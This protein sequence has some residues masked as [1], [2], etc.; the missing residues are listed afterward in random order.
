MLFSPTTG[1][2]QASLRLHGPS[3][4][5]PP[6]ARLKAA[7]PSVAFQGSIPPLRAAANAA[8]PPW[9]PGSPARPCS[10]L[11][12]L[13]FGSDTAPLIGVPLHTAPA[14]AKPD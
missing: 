2:S 14:P 10:A 4:L 13:A 5:L 3:R 8:C 7:L 9:G 1:V 11:A 12:L 6:P